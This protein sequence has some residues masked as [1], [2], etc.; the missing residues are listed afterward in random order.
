MTRL[1]RDAPRVFR[2]ISA[3]ELSGMFGAA[4]DV[5]NFLS[6]T[7]LKGDDP[8]G[9]SARTNVSIYIYIYIYIDIYIYIYIYIDI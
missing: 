3:L 2:L 5:P 7:G 6:N 8:A 1:W 4:F 9:P